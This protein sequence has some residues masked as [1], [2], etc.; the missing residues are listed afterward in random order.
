MNVDQFEDVRA[1][2]NR[3]DRDGALV[4]LEE[5]LKTLTREDAEELTLVR[6]SQ[7]RSKLFLLLLEAV[8]KNWLLG[9][10]AIMTRVR[11]LSDRE[12]VLDGEYMH[13]AS[14]EGHL[15]MIELLFRHNPRLLRQETLLSYV[16]MDY[17]IMHKRYKAVKLL[18]S[19]GCTA[20]E[21]KRNAVV[22]ELFV[23]ASTGCTK[24]VKAV[25]AIIP[26]EID[27]GVGSHYRECAIRRECTPM[28]EAAFHRK[29]MKMVV[30]L[31]T[32]GSQSH[33]TSSFQDNGA[34]A[35]SLQEKIIGQRLR[36]FYFSRSLVEVLFFVETNHG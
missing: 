8:S 15:D 23:A 3:K 16:P 13:A 6:P 32:L 7:Q 33:F 19:L 25:H 4:L 9:A 24:T 11:E 27:S 29:D 31:H 22:R 10:N 1:A 17:A 28:H 34:P 35:D 18:H 21:Q 20:L 2:L 26:W 30:C 14:R 12:N 5:K 36:A